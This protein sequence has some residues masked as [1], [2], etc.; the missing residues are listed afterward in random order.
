MKALTETVIC[1]KFV[2]VIA[3]LTMQMLQQK[4]VSQIWL[5]LLVRNRPVYSRSDNVRKITPTRTPSFKEKDYV[6]SLFSALYSTL[7]KNLSVIE[8]AW[9]ITLEM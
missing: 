6:C 4:P 8:L 3:A 7:A 9:Y 2:K 1:S 5:K